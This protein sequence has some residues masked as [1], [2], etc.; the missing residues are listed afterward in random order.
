MTWNRARTFH[1]TSPHPSF[2]PR[3]VRTTTEVA[4][5]TLALIFESKRGHVPNRA[6]DINAGHFSRS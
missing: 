4:R 3:V 2:A 5:R 6:L 1:R